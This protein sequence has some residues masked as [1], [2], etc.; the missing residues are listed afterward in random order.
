MAAQKIL[1][2]SVTKPVHACRRHRQRGA[3]AVMTGIFMVAALAALALAIDVGRLYFAQRDL[4]RITNLSALDAARA[5]SGCVGQPDDPQAAAQTAVNNAINRN[6]SGTPSG[7]T[8]ISNSTVALGQIIEDGPDGQPLEVRTID[9]G[10][11]PFDA[12]SVQVTLQNPGFNRLFPLFGVPTGT[13]SATAA[14]TS[15]PTGSIR[16]GS[17]LISIGGLDGR[18]GLLSA[19]LGGPVNLDLVAFE[20]LA[21]A[22]VSIA[23]LVGAA[24]GVVTPEELLVTE[25]T[26][27]EALQALADAVDETTAGTNDIAKQALDDLAAIADPDRTASFGDILGVEDVIANAVDE[28]PINVLALLNALALAA[29]EDTPTA[30][31]LP[32]NAPL[33]GLATVTSQLKV[34]E[35]PQLDVGRPGMDADGEPRTVARTSQVAIEL[36]LNIPGINIP[37][38]LNTSVD[39]PLFIKATSAEATLDDIACARFGRP[40]HRATVGTGTSIATIGIGRFDDINSQNP[41]P[42]VEPLEILTAEVL[43]VPID[44]VLNPIDPV[45]AGSGAGNQSLDFTGPFPPEE[46]AEPQTARVGTDVGDALAAALGDLAADIPGALEL[47]INGA[48]PLGVVGG[49]LAPLLGIV[50]NTIAPV[51]AALDD[52]LLEPLFEALGLDIGAA[53]VTLD[54]V[55]VDQPIL[56]IN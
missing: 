32:I 28:L 18:N 10:V 25:L 48:D 13:L 45:D 23:D 9:T 53:D 33:P 21:A 26:L 50:G 43:G 49:L 5:I 55:L 27:P 2:Y 16:V 3:A 36:N 15:V 54:A 1:S 6:V 11:D 14:A 20:G 38:V 39:L 22:D 17:T 52:V 37:G 12:D 47:N 56:F 40:E 41:Q 34:I 30:L 24:A 7:A 31:D 51:L 35:A 44:V 29:N 46:G 4:Q 8:L 42:T 19:L